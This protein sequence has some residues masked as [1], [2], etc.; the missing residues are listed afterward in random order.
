MEPGPDEY[1]APQMTRAQNFKMT[2][3]KVGCFLRKLG[4]V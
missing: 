1:T 2:H 3:P 4:R